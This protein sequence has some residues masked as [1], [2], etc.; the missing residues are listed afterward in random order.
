MAL[1][2]GGKTTG[3][4]RRL[5]LDFAARIGLAERAATRTVD[6]VLVATEEVVEEW[7]AGAVPFT[8]QV[9]REVTRNLWNR[10][11]TVL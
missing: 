8:A 9:V 1:A 10:R 2:M 7:L 4:S 3:L 6:Q 11:R 5:L